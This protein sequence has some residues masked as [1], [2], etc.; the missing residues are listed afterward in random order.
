MAR[1]SRSRCAP[2]RT[3]SSATLRSTSS[4]ATYEDT[5][6]I[7]GV[8]LVRGVPAG[9]YAGKVKVMATIELRAELAKTRLFGQEI[10]LGAAAFVDAGRVSA[11]PERASPELDGTGLGIKYGLGAG[12]RARVGTSSSFEATWRGLPTPS[13]SGRISRRAR[14][15]DVPSAPL[16]TWPSG[17]ANPEEHTP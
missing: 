10:F 3:C 7:G 15:F 8:N 5:H 1:V 11:D 13:P 16:A 2:S 4:R 17:A 9:R 6:A 14:P 12:P